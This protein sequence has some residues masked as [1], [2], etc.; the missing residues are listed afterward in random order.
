MLDKPRSDFKMGEKLVD[1]LFLMKHDVPSNDLNIIHSGMR[2]TSKYVSGSYDRVTTIDQS[3]L[4]DR[5]Q[6]KYTWERKKKNYFDKLKNSTD[7]NVLAAYFMVTDN[8]WKMKGKYNLSRINNSKLAKE[9]KDLFLQ[10]LKD[11]GVIQLAPKLFSA[12]DH[13]RIFTVLNSDKSARLIATSTKINRSIYPFRKAVLPK[14]KDIIDF[15]C[16]NVGGMTKAL[17]TQ[18]ADLEKKISVVKPPMLGI[19][20]NKLNTLKENHIFIA[21]I[22]LK[23]GFFNVK[24]NKKDRR[25][26][27]FW[28]NRN[29]YMFKRLPM[30]IADVPVRF[31]NHIA[32]VLVGPTR[33]HL[34]RMFPSD[35]F[36]INNYIDD[37]IMIGT[38]RALV[39][40]IKFLL[41]LAK[42]ANLLINYAKSNL[43]PV[44][45]VD[46]L[47]TVVDL[48]TMKCSAKPPQITKA[49]IF[50]NTWPTPFMNAL[51][52]FYFIMELMPPPILV[53]FLM[54]SVYRKALSKSVATAIFQDVF[55]AL[56]K[57]NYEV[58][59]E[60]WHKN[61]I[62]V[63]EAI[64][65][66][67]YSG[68]YDDFDIE[69]WNNELV[70]TLYGAFPEYYDLLIEVAG[71]KMK[72]S[73]LRQLLARLTSVHTDLAPIAQET[74]LAHLKA[75]KM[76]IPTKYL[77]DRTFNRRYNQDRYAVNIYPYNPK[78]TINKSRI[79]TKVYDFGPKV[80]FYLKAV[81]AMKMKVKKKPKRKI[82]VPRY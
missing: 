74:L 64:M 82:S 55:E 20:Q 62:I 24:I 12:Y 44:R 7:P 79:E 75:S 8:W 65:V 63:N 10:A 3:E 38:N 35:M 25:W 66:I 15:I 70:L 4:N 22:D 26:F 37:I 49:R 48:D 47:G 39:L 41:E 40:A 6:V 29:L 42:A 28:W 43:T 73:P 19:F 67:R 16:K 80:N 77:K 1:P 72:V 30:G 51:G 2:Y 23:K 14:G 18:I 46:I 11:I 13:M 52:L 76:V 69:A 50:M 31:Q 78:A 33:R 81:D 61:Y 54:M 58:T 57:N 71:I 32:N 21:K 59:M 53:Y 45:R 27:T 9:Q 56:E 17:N 36:L 60:T 68:S 5:K 34:A